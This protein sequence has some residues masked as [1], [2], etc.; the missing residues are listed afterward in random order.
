MEQVQQPHM[1]EHNEKVRTH[2][3]QS[4]NE[5]NGMELVQITV[6]SDSNTGDE[7]WYG[8]QIRRYR[9]TR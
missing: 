9:S 6:N 3:H 7:R 1:I 4:A 8:H 2:I 5:E